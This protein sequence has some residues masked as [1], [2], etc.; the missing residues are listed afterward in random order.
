[1]T[2]AAGLLADENVPGVV[3]A[4]LRQQGHDLAWIREDPPGSPDAE[5]LERAQREHRVS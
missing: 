3:V 4:A 1:M 5:V 2:V